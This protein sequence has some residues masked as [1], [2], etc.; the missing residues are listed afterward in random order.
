MLAQTQAATKRRVGAHVNVLAPIVGSPPPTPVGARKDRAA[1]GAGLGL[2]LGRVASAMGKENA[3]A[4]R[5]HS[6]PRKPVPQ[7]VS[8]EF[9]PKV[10][11]KDREAV[12][13]P[14]GA[15][16]DRTAHARNVENVKE[17]VKKVGAVAGAG[18]VVAG[19]Q[20]SAAVEEGEGN[21]QVEEGKSMGS[22]R[23]RMREWER[24]RERLRETVMLSPPSSPA[25]ESEQEQGWRIRIAESAERG[26]GER[27]TRSED[28][29]REDVHTRHDAVR[30]SKTPTDSVPSTPVSPGMKS[31]C[32]Y[33]YRRVT[34][35]VRTCACIASSRHEFLHA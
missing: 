3:A 13:R 10:P 29:L 1:G 17:N 26:E 16:V 14:G 30:V 4:P 27:R 33:I 24:E 35:T 18:A 5:K 25:T 12:R 28:I 11:P 7:V 23:D 15:L 19:A 2:G 6:V 34:L 22:V 21:S 32:W 20:K 9:A 8:R 31:M